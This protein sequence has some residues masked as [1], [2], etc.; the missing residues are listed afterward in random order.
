MAIEDKN[1]YST[2]E[3]TAPHVIIWSSAFKNSDAYFQSNPLSV[4]MHGVKWADF[5]PFVESIRIPEVLDYYRKAG[6]KLHKYLCKIFALR[7]LFINLFKF[8][9]KKY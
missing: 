1:I 7:K 9:F 8:I 5:Y 6:L 2:F 3:N 4:N